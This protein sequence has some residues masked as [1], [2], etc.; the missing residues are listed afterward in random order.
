MK[1]SE[2]KQLIKEEIQKVLS[3]GLFDRFK[4]TPIPD[5]KFIK[6]FPLSDI[7]Q[8]MDDFEKE[9][10]VG[11]HPDDDRNIFTHLDKNYK[12]IMGFATEDRWRKDISDNETIVA[13][14]HPGGVSM[15]YPEIFFIAKKYYKK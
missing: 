5:Y 4:K 13:L 14:Q 11:E 3:E 10:E 8:V 15:Y 12:P 6:E 1:H 2:L 7:E 9:Y